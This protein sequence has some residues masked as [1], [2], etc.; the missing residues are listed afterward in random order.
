MLEKSFLFSREDILPKKTG[1]KPS[2]FLCHMKEKY[3]F[4]F[5][6]LKG[7]FWNSHGLQ[8]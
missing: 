8:C 2:D 3:D 4:M 7:L 1:Y 6:S 5:Y